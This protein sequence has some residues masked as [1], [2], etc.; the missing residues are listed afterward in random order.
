MTGVTIHLMDESLDTGP[1]VLQER[2]EVPDGISERALE[3]QLASCGAR[4]L[5]QALV[6]LAS[7][8]LNPVAQDSSQATRYP[9]PAPMD[10]V[11]TPDLPARRAYN[12]ASGM[13][14]RT[15]PIL[16][17]VEDHTFQLLEPLDFDELADM[18]EAWHL[19][20]RILILSCAPGV[21]RARVALIPRE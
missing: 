19:D 13:R 17:Q 2:V 11:I 21:F 10:W 9:F 8:S 3:E 20:G 5:A 1:V 12:F 16:I 15:Q 7:G 18:E 14:A 6:G 4:L